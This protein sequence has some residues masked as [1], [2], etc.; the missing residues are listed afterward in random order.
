MKILLLFLLLLSPVV[1]AVDTYQF[2]NPEKQAAYDSLV[3]EL[4]CLVC[5]NQT[6]GD[7]NAELAADL[8]RQVYEMLQQGKSQA[9]IQQFMT[10]RYGDFVLYNPPF[11]AKTG[12]LWLGPVVFLAVGLLAVFLFTRRKKTVLP[13][14]NVAENAEK[15]A[16][17][18]RLLTDKDTENLS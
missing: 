1:N 4:R 13:A 10:D 5:Q 8:R 7:S 3:S 9:E 15:L 18:R 6:I 12:L 16:A 11:K 2:N 17:A 14:D